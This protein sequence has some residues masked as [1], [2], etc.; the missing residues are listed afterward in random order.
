MIL[1]NNICKDEEICLEYETSFGI[2]WN[3]AKHLAQQFM[4]YQTVVP[5]IEYCDSHKEPTTVI[6][7]KH[8][9]DSIFKLQELETEHKELIIHGTMFITGCN[10]QTHVGLRIVTN[11]NK[12]YLYIYP[13]NTNAKELFKDNHTLDVFMNRLEIEATVHESEIDMM[14]FMDSYYTHVVYSVNNENYTE[15]ELDSIKEQYNDL[16]D[17]YN[18]RFD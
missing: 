18:I 2:S 15:E 9:N 16:L 12:I 11:S 7:L 1:I 17:K 10:G 13:G 14:K 4:T 8:I 5:T 6:K 3:L